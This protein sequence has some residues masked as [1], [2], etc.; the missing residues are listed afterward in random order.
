[1][2]GI[3]EALYRRFV[4]Q[5]GTSEEQAFLDS[6]ENITGPISHT[7]SHEGILAVYEKLD[8]EGKKV[9]ERIY[10]HSYKPAFDIL[11]EMY[12]EVS[13]CN[14]IRSVIMAGRRH[15]RFPMGK[16]DGTRM[17][18]VGEKVRANRSGKEAAINP[19][20]AGIYVATMMAQID[21]L[22]EKGHCLSEVANE[23]V[24]EAVDSLNPYMHHKGVAFMVDN[25]STTA[26]LGSRKWAP[27]FDYNLSQQ[28]LVDY[29]AGLPA[30]QAQ[31]TAFKSNKI[32]QALATC[33]SF[34]PPVDIAFV[35]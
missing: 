21:L 24:I 25:C 26:R 35:D 8:A 1:V 29:D 31:I 14:E 4:M 9:F 2:H 30:D 19:F 11:L 33:A 16:I 10:S 13:S 22:M 27:R 20:T 28:A 34:R 12:D 17:W 32:H 5:D 7:I 6:V 23:S 18:Q 15:A 3:V